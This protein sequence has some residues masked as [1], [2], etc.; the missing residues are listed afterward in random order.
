MYEPA[1][2]DHDGRLND[3]YPPPPPRTGSSR[4]GSARSERSAMSALPPP[5]INKADT[6]PPPDPKPFLQSSASTLYTRSKKDAIVQRRTLISLPPIKP[7]EIGQLAVECPIKSNM[8]S[9]SEKNN[10]TN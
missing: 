8:P 10:A 3:S 4:S 6:V 7:Y 1:L 2:A 5:T 9:A